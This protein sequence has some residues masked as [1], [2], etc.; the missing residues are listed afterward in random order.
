M[1]A[2]CASPSFP[3]SSRSAVT[4]SL[5]GQQCV[6]SISLSSLAINLVSALLSGWFFSL[7]VLSC[8]CSF[9]HS[10][11]LSNTHTHTH[12]Q[13]GIILPTHQLEMATVAVVVF[14]LVSVFVVFVDHWESHTW[15]TA[16]AASSSSFSR[17]PARHK[18]P[19][20]TAPLN[21]D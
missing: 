20:T 21:S 5:S 15:L 7:L 4:V 3:S 13:W 10:R 16:T 8:S 17:Q 18:Q 2:P 1:A 14:L 11:L 6:I 19:R 12:T 9:T